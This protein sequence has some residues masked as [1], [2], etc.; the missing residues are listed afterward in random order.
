MQRR[1]LMKKYL[2]FSPLVFYYMDNIS[3]HPMGSKKHFFCPKCK[4]TVLT[5]GG[6]D[7]G[8]RAATDTFCCKDC[9]ILMDL[10]VER[11]RAGD[12]FPD[13]MLTETDI[14]ISSPVTGGGR[15]KKC[16]GQNIVIW[17]NKLRPCPKCGTGMESDGFR[18]MLWD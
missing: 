1:D 10:F 7:G 4:Y 18:V 2:A 11:G 12:P 13:I 14:K 8:M 17:D 9:K 15:C 3:K 16:H 5:S 6:P